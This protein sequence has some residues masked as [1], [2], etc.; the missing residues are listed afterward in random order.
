MEI[1]EVAYFK[2]NYVQYMTQHFGKQVV[3]AFQS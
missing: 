1:E 2:L 3:L